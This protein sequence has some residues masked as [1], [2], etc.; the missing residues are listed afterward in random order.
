[1][2][3]SPTTCR[4]SAWA[5]VPVKQLSDVKSRLAPVLSVAQRAEL[6]MAMLADVLSALM[7]SESLQGVAVVTRDDGIAKFA[8]DRSCSV[9][10]ES[11]LG[12][13]LNAALS[14][15]LAKLREIGATRVLIVPADI[16]LID[17]AEI[18][19]VVNLGRLQMVLVVPSHD[20]AGTNGLLVHLNSPP[21]LSF[22]R[23]SFRKHLNPPCGSAMQVSAPSFGLDIDTP[24]DLFEVDSIIRGRNQNT[25]A[26]HT[27]PWLQAHLE[28]KEKCRS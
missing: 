5:L 7:R 26:P 28:V 1:M 2:N 23:D 17:V 24:A 22:G 16:P 8:Q 11:P 27:A 19:E 18:D 12:N 3:S 21:Q 25:V 6:Q 14:D 9:V 10:E 13:G 15:G 20:R 4:E